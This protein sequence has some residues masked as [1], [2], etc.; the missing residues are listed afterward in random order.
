MQMPQCFINSSIKSKE[1]QKK[2]NTMATIT[3]VQR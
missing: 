1:A 3:K 2:E